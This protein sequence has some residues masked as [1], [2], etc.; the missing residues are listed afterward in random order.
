MHRRNGRAAHRLFGIYAVSKDNSSFA[1]RSQV[2]LVVSWL[3][4]AGDA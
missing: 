3:S 2:V 4:L 1:E